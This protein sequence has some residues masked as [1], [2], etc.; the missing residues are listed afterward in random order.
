[1]SIRLDFRRYT[2]PFRGPVRT[3]HGPWLAR[4]GILVRTEDEAGRTGYGEAAPIP[5]FGSETVAEDEAA[6]AGLGG[7]VEA[8][9]LDR[10][11]E[12]VGCL[13]FA[14]AC[15]LGPEPGAAPAGQRLPVAALLPA[16]RAACAAAD[17]ALETGH[18][19]FKWKVG[20]FDDADERVMLDDLLARLPGH[21]RLRLD[22]NGAWTPRRAMKW[23]EC[24]A[25]RPIEFVEQPCF[26][27]AAEG[28]DEQRRAEDA[29]VGLAA[30]Y[31]TPIALDES[32]TGLPSLRAWLAR[33]W[34]GVLVVKP[35]LAGDPASLLSLLERS[36]ADVVFSSAFE[37]RLGR[38]AALRIAFA[39]QGPRPR[40]LGFGVGPLFADER[41]DTEE[42]G[43]F[44]TP[45][46]VGRMKAETLW[47]VLI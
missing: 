4:E 5:W 31:P 14:L 34:R 32:V 11:D 37:T 3:A 23:L 21:A 22:A 25:E 41:F 17:Q 24:C 45:E 13:R 27:G 12:T 42:P 47:N 19:A 1:M 43:A 28:A 6:L 33:G 18:V 15:A 35:A 30:D 29:L 40:A 16:G 8:G 2:L 7:V 46:D 36:R 10:I 39:Y 26:A 38:Q 20:V 44:L 9:A